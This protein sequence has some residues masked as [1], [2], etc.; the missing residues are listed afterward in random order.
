MKK[1]PTPLASG[2]ISKGL[3][4]PALAQS[5]T[6]SS[7][8]GVNIAPPSDADQRASVVAEVRSSASTEVRKAL[9]LKLDDARYRALKLA[10]LERSKS[11]QEILVEALDRW[12]EQTR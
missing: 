7:S 1:P 5:D 11:S 2:L 8:Q 4:A 10:G 6:E 3:A 12:L 9:T